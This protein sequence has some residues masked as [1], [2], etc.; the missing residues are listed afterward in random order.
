MAAVPG[1]VLSL[2]RLFLRRRAYRIR[3]SQASRGFCFEAAAIPREVTDSAFLVTLGGAVYSQ[4]ISITP[5]TTGK[6]ALK[7]MNL[8]WESKAREKIGRSNSLKVGVSG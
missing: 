7:S 1:Y 4:P 3:F 8:G 2:F 5:E 6:I